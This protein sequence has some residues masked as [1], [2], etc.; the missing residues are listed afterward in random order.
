M[1]LE[2]NPPSAMFITC[3]AWKSGDDR[4]APMPTTRSWVCGA[5][6]LSTMTTRGRGRRRR[7]RAPAWP[8]C[9][10]GHAPNA[11][12]AS[13]SQLGHRDVA[14]HD[15]RGVVRH[16]VLLPERL[17][18]VA[19]HRL[20][21]R[22][23]ADLGE[24]VRMALAVERRGHHV[25]RDLPRRSRAA[26]PA[27]P[28]GW[29]AAARFR[30]PETTGAARHRPSGPASRRS[31]SS[32]SAPT[33]TSRPSS[34]RVPSVAPSCASSSAICSALRVVVPWSSI[35]AVKFARPGLSSGFASL[36]VR[37]TRLAATTGRPARL[38]RISVRPLAS[39]VDLAASA[40]CSGCGG[41][42]FGG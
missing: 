25:G 40:S 19:R 2:N 28:A 13:G 33:R 17:H 32:A 22:L 8:A 35:A 21:R 42:A 14:G 7:C 1:R 41:P 12:S 4:G 16:E 38:L 31:S 11:F 26:A 27:A 15:E 6:G 20:H 9:P 18:V 39:C 24:A 30:R 34:C 37:T 29:R 5:P 36:P 10:R 23:G 3:I